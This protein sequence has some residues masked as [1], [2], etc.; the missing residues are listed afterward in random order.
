VLAGDAFLSGEWTRAGKALTFVGGFLA[1]GATFPKIRGARLSR[2]VNYERGFIVAG[3]ICL[4]IFLVL[5]GIQHFMYTEFVASLIPSWFPGDAVVWTYFAGVC[6]I[7]G[8]VGL[9]IPSTA[10]IAALLSGVMVFSWFWIVHLPRTFVGV[11][12]SIAIFEALA[13]SGIAFVL[14]GYLGGSTS[15][16]RF[17]F[18]RKERLVDSPYQVVRE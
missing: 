10:P 6:L 15:G 7:S 2:F 13:V 8:G 1:I 5:T 11:S 9:F 18:R 12:D 3:R 14:A 4:G 17:G 16:P